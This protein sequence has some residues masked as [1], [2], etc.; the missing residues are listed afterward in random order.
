MSL[1]INGSREIGNRHC[2]KSRNFPNQGENSDFT[3]IKGDFIAMNYKFMLHFD[4]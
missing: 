2:I 4:L 3:N 1:T